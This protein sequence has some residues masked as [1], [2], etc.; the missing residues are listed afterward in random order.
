MVLE[1][2][3]VILQGTVL[4]VFGG[5]HIQV[6]GELSQEKAPMGEGKQWGASGYQSTQTLEIMIICFSP[7]SLGL[8][9]KACF[10]QTTEKTAFGNCF[11]GLHGAAGTYT[12]R[13]LTGQALTH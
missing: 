4:L 11:F 1:H 9:G 8:I 13:P 12:V 10:L 6:A 2:P 7:S 5:L 3:Q